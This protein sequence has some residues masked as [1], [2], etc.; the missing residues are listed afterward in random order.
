[1]AV[2]YR[3]VDGKLEHDG[4]IMNKAV[5]LQYSGPVVKASVGFWPA[6]CANR[7]SIELRST[8]PGC[9]PPT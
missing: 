1:L 7:P 5:K 8:D 6:L 2:G 9:C 3:Y 4:D